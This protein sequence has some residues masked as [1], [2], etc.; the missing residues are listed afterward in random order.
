MIIEWKQFDNGSD[1]ETYLNEVYN[2]FKEVEV[3]GITQGI[4]FNIFVKLGNE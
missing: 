1:V 3:L 4:K 2:S